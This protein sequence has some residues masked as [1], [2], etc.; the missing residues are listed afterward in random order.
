M[1]RIGRQ[2][3]FSFSFQVILVFREDEEANGENCLLAVLS[4]M[5][6]VAAS[7]ADVPLA[8]LAREIIGAMDS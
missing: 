1:F 6:Q 2:P 7:H 4:R 5:S 8:S 3:W